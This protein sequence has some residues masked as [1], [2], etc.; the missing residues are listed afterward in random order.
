MDKDMLRGNNQPSIYHTVILW[1]LC[2]LQQ[3]QVV[4]FYFFIVYISHEN[5]H[6]QK[7]IKFMIFKF[8]IK[9][10]LT[11]LTANLDKFFKL[12]C[13]FNIF[14]PTHFATYIILKNICISNVCFPKQWSNCSKIMYIVPI[15]TKLKFSRNNYF[16]W[17]Q[18]LSNIMNQYQ[19]Y[20]ECII[21]SN[22]MWKWI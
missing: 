10:N 20:E 6:L 13:F 16:Y 2:L 17:G 12:F 14:L 4:Y 22:K 18:V 7:V 8:Y 21:L 15:F 9:M 5:K 19:H 1:L 3:E 11:P